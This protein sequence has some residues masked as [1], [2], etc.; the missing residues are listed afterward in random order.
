MIGA[1]D[2]VYGAIAWCEYQAYLD[3]NEFLWQLRIFPLA[4][5]GPRPPAV[6]WRAGARKSVNISQLA[7]MGS[8]GIKV[9][10]LQ[11]RRDKQVNK[12]E[13]TWQGSM[14]RVLR[15]KVRVGSPSHALTVLRQRRCFF[16]NGGAHSVRRIKDQ[17]S[18]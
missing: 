8:S 15:R 11:Y 18:E 14:V 2:K 6:T 10:V 16:R 17:L 13:F 5:D 9:R 3:R 7:W 1:R 12:V 4:T